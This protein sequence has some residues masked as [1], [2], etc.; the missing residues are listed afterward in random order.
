MCLFIFF[1]KQKTAYEMRI[2]DWSSDV[3]SSD[4]RY[5]AEL[6]AADMQED[7]AARMAQLAKAEADV[8]KDYPVMP[9]YFTTARRIVSS[10]VHG[11]H[12]AKGGNMQ[13][14]WLSLDAGKATK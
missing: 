7:P 9:I 5:D 8:M 13:S 3:C 12:Q 6:A 4:L 2:S 1:F 11:W 14:R 10:R